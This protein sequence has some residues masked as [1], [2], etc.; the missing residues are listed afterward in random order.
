MW[1]ASKIG[2]FSIVTKDGHLHVRA[3][4]RR[5]LE[6]LLAL[7]GFPQASIESWPHADYR[8]R[9]RLDLGAAGVV[10][11]ALAETV[12]YPNFK[13]EV[14]CRPDQRGKL[15]AY[16][17]LWHELLAIQEE[18]SAVAAGDPQGSG[19]GSAGGR[20]TRV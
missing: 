10:L 20:R 14:A 3:R 17:H 12:D 7:P 13:S 11:G 5:D 4:L 8:W 18:R 9:I 15:S 2:F 19:R 16:H 6:N 1:I